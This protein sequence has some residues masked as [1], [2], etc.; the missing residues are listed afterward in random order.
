M[1][2]K[3]CSVLTM[4]DEHRRLL[5]HEIGPESD[6]F[7]HSLVKNCLVL[8]MDDEHQ[9]LPP[10]EIGPE[11]GHLSTQFNKELPRVDHG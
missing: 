11:T 1:S 9:K 8:T 10:R 2:L 7:I 4:V 6:I 5:P 3:N